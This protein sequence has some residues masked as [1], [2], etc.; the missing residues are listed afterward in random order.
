MEILEGLNEEQLSAVKHGEGPMLVV[1]GAGTGKTQVISR[2]IALLISQNKARPSQILSLTFTEKAAREME[3]RLY[4]LIG[5]QSFQVPVMTFNAFGAELLA[6]Y[7]SHIGR[8]TGGGLL[9]SSQK[10]LLLQQHI[11]QIDFKYYGAQSNLFEFAYIEKLQNA[12]IE[13]EDYISYVESLRSDTSEVHPS[14]IL[15][16][17]DLAAFYSL[18]EDIKMKSGTYDYYDQLSLPVKILRLRPNL[19]SRLSNQYRY[20]LVDEYQD[21]SPI[22]DELLRSFVPVDGNIFAVGDDDQSI[23]SFR[24]ADI[25]NI[26]SFTSHFSGVKPSVLVRNYRSGQPILD[27][28]YKLIQ[29][30]NPDRLEARLSLDKRLVAQNADGKVTFRSYESSA[31]ERTSIAIEISERIK[32]GL[33]PSDIAVLAR[34]NAPLKALAKNLKN[35]AVPFLLSADVDIFTNTEVI[36]L[37][38][39]LQWIGGKADFDAVSHV[40]IGPF[41]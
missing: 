11:E 29:G 10:A 24:G 14:D 20:I 18:Y 34:S 13:P 27:A 17:E 28:A 31:D 12:A 39:L 15:E 33:E 6:R 36:N 41:F 2:R 7:S 35:L 5:W 30:N 19:A 16:Q 37:W 3:E 25:D 8:S 32:R 1:A 21:T 26:L 23:Y 9:T 22:Q 40:L 38:Y 4:S